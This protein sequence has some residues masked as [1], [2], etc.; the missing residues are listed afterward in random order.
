MTLIG[1]LGNGKL[2]LF[3]N[4]INLD[5]FPAYVAQFPLL[6]TFSLQLHQMSG[7]SSLSTT[8]CVSSTW[9]SCAH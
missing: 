8:S 7:H 6:V 3:V 5:Q 2:A 4:G 9:R 1:V